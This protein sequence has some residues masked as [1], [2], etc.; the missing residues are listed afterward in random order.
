M[1]LVYP[2]GAWVGGILL[3]AHFD[4]PPVIILVGLAPLPFIHR[5][6]HYRKTLI[7]VSLC[8]LAAGGRAL[9]YGLSRPVIGE[10][11]VA[12]YNGVDDIALQGMVA[13]IPEITE[14]SR[15]LRLA[16]SELA[17]DGE[18]REVSGTVLITTSRYPDYD[19]GDEIQV[20]GSLEAPQPFNDFDYPAYLARQG[21]YSTLY[22]PEI[23]VVAQGQGPPAP[24]LINN[25]RQH[26]S[27][28]L[29]RVLPEPQAALAQAIVLGIRDNIPDSLSGDFNRTGTAHLLAISGLHLSILAG[30]MVSFGR[31]LLGRRHYLYVWLT[32]A[33]IWLYALITGMHPPVIRAA[34]M[35]SIFLA[36]EF[37]GRQRSALTALALTA[38]I[39]V[40][41]EPEILWSASFQMSFTAMAGLI[42]ITPILQ[43][44]WQR[45]FRARETAKR[46]AGAGPR[47][48]IE[49]FN[50]SLGALIGVGPLTAYYFGVISLVGPPAT[51]LAAPAIP[52]I[53]ILGALSAVTGLASLAV[54]QFFGWLT[55]LPLS[56]LLLIVRAFAAIPGI[57]LSVTSVP[58]GALAAY[59]LVLLTAI[60]L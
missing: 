5:F 32:L 8:L 45:Y 4:L 28:N 12:S 18:W 59:Y 20:S 52:A 13:E 37:L 51:L 56:Y 38:I 55:W 39:M 41:I 40:A 14:R 23:T 35:V 6:H 42:L 54:A 26:L 36:G 2:A 1:T 57:S 22:Y 47:T 19:Y 24:T 31:R 34:V 46:P 48:I 15:Q 58:I 44:W 21:I 16:V 33:V 43:N 49:A 53:I 11:R 10:T 25:L 17:A 7:L 27:Q 30:I 3:G 60:W 9:R 29:I 50:I